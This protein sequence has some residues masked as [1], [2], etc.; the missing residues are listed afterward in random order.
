MFKKY[1]KDNK[2]PKEEANTI[3]SIM[4]WAHPRELEIAIYSIKLLIQKEETD[5]EPGPGYVNQ[6]R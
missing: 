1:I 4:H 2:I 3:Y 6:D 5:S